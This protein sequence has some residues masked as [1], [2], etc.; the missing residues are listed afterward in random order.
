L[1]FS[2]FLFIRTLLFNSSYLS[3]IY[4]SAYIIHT[5]S[6]C[7]NCCGFVCF[8]VLNQSL[9][10]YLKVHILQCKC[11]KTFIICL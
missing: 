6:L 8:D 3:F 5:D 7:W 1:K 4:L 10:L 9:W 11:L 2:F